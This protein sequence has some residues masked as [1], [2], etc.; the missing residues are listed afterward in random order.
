MK[1]LY[2]LCLASCSILRDDD[3]KEGLLPSGINLYNRSLFRVFNDLTTYPHGPVAHQ[4][5]STLRGLVKGPAG[6]PFKAEDVLILNDGC[7]QGSIKKSMQTFKK[8]FP[9]DATLVERS[10][11]RLFGGEYTPLGNRHETG[12]KGIKYKDIDTQMLIDVSHSFPSWI[13][14]T[15]DIEEEL[16]AQEGT[17]AVFAFI[18]RKKISG[19][20]SKFLKQDLNLHAELMAFEQFRR[21]KLVN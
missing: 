13:T 16:Y 17:K 18:T 21:K 3:I 15:K 19:N 8:R 12:L 11:E 7:S 1:T 2:F 14:T 6:R 20:I 5:Y 4:V 9:W 10:L